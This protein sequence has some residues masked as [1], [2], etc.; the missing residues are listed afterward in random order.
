MLFSPAKIKGELEAVLENVDH[1]I[2]LVNC[3]I[4]RKIGLGYELV[5]SEKSSVMSS[6][7]KKFQVNDDLMISSRLRSVNSTICAELKELL[8]IDGVAAQ[9]GNKVSVVGKVVSVKEMDEIKSEKE[10]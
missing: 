9:V 8:E 4:K 7:N 2:S 5:L 10:G 6:P 3:D 1:G